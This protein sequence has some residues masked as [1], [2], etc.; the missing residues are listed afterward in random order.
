[1]IL[2]IVIVIIIIII[3]IDRKEGEIKRCHKNGGT[4][5]E[6]VRIG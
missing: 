1:M 2:I 6:A 4:H 5:R 3:M